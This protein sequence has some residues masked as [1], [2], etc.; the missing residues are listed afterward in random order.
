MCNKMI[1]FQ[2]LLSVMHRWRK[3]AY[4]SRSYNALSDYII[5]DTVCAKDAEE[6]REQLQ[7]PLAPGFYGPALNCDD[8]VHTEECKFLGVAVLLFKD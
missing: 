4:A 5:A 7:T 6:I 3:E 1:T 2:I 8:Q